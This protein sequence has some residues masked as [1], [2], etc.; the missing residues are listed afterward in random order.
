M[1]DSEFCHR[2]GWPKRY[3]KES[4]KYANMP[5]NSHE[6][7]HP[8]DPVIGNRYVLC[9]ATGFDGLTDEVTQQSSREDV[10]SRIERE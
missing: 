2:K 3:F 6:G 8:G 1:K 10:Q 9:P 7:C 4:R 5:H